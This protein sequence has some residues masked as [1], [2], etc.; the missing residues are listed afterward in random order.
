MKKEKIKVL[1]ICSDVQGV[2]HFRSI[3]PAISIQENFKDEV[4]VE[5]NPKS[6]Y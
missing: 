4:E 5:I 1:M 2:G 6:K 3:W